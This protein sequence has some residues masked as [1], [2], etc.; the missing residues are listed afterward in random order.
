MAEARDIAGRS[1]ASIEALWVVSL[2]TYARIPRSPDWPKPQISS[3]IAAREL[4]LLEGV[5]ADAIYGGPK[6]ELSRLA[7]RVDLLILGSRSYGPLHRVFLGTTST[8]LTRHAGCPILQLPR[9]GRTEPLEP[10]Q[11]PGSVAR[12]RLKR[13]LTL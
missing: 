6:E 11:E 2:W 1:E 5:R 7:D 8:Y 12:L 10:T 4:E 13:R 9:A 3:S